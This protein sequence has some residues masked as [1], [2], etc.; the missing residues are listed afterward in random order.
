MWMRE[1]NYCTTQSKAKMKRKIALKNMKK[2]QYKLK[3]T[4]IGK[5]RNRESIKVKNVIVNKG[6]QL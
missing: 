2:L 1:G 6:I 4:I 3:L 5:Y